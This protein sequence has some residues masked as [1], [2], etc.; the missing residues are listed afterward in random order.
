MSSGA[1]ESRTPL[2]ELGEAAARQDPP[3][4]CL[5]LVL[6]GLTVESPNDDGGF[7]KSPLEE[8]CYPHLDALAREG[9]SGLL[10]VRKGTYDGK[11]WLG[12]SVT[13][14]IMD[15]VIR[16]HGEEGFKCNM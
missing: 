1:P 3:P 14:Y 4:T 2:N 15:G 12:W 6:T 10:A 7:T 11:Y 5:L 16:G 13:G 8:G 9:C